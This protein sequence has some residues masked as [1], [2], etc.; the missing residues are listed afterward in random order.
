MLRFFVHTGEGDQGAR[1][2]GISVSGEH[3]GRAAYVH[4]S[5]EC[6]LRGGLFDAL[7]FSLS[8]RRVRSSR[9]ERRRD[10]GRRDQDRGQSG[11]G[12]RARG[13][14]DTSSFE[15]LSELISTALQASAPPTGGRSSQRTLGVRALLERVGGEISRQ[16]ESA[17]AQS[18]VSPE[19]G[20]KGLP[21]VGKGVGKI[22]F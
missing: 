12:Q 2:F 19:K 5:P 6:A 16:L 17:A 1:G 22:R 21:R 4:A 10:Q 18:I 11:Q 20:T 3:S 14:R 9:K 8:A 15:L 13:L 7:R